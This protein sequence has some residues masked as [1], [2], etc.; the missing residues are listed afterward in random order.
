MTQ[1]G[2]YCT[3]IAPSGSGGMRC[4]PASCASV[5]LSAGWQSDPWDLTLQLDAQ[6][7]PQKDGTTSQDLIRL[8]DGYGFDGREWYR[9]D[10]V[11]PAIAAG[12]AVLCL[13]Y[14]AWLEPRPY[15]PGAGWN[16]MHWLRCLYVGE[17]GTMCYV[18]D[19][20]AY[21]ANS[22]GSWYQGPTLVT[23]ESLW[24]AIMQ[25]GY[26]DAG[27]ILHSRAGA[28]LNDSR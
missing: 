10:E 24:A 20:L 1:I 22:D 14:N 2:D 25:T 8:M 28:D 26:P 17:G 15:P 6:V 9:W 11:G 19:P 16:A 21:I 4:G 12:D 5:L 3:Q 13:N 23:R 18:Y 27:I 7:D